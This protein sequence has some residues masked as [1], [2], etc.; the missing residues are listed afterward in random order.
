MVIYLWSHSMIIQATLFTCIQINIVDKIHRATSE[1]WKSWVNVVCS[2]C[3]LDD[4]IFGCLRWQTYRFSL[5]KL[6]NRFLNFILWVLVTNKA[7]T[8]NYYMYITHVSC[9]WFE[10]QKFSDHLYL[11]TWLLKS[12]KK[13]CHREIFLWMATQGLFGNYWDLFNENW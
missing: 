10:L 8:L 12:C 3:V 7:Y 2:F 9:C 5:C 1:R 11:Y 4:I 6:F 13:I